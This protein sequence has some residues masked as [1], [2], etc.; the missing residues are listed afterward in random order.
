MLFKRCYRVA[1][2]LFALAILFSHAAMAEP[3]DYIRLPIVEYGER[4]IDFKSGIQRNRDGTTE[5]AH[6]IGYGTTPSAWWF[7]ELYGKYARAPGESTRFDAWEWENRF[8]LTETG[9]YPIDLGLLLEIERPRD[10]SEGYEFTFGP[11]LQTEWGNVQAN[12]NV[13]LRR[14]LKAAEQF[15]REL[16]FQMQ[17]KYRQSRELEWGLQGFGN[18]AQWNHWLPASQQEFKIGPALFGKIKTGTKQAFKWNAAILTGTTTASPHT[19]FRL[20]AE[21]EF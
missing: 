14:H 21:Y 16:L 17:L 15:D 10:R 7:T 3:N 19:T 18:V 11:L 13:L 9:R 6:S 2:C 4:E 8:Q 1:Q 20:Q 5:S 12:A